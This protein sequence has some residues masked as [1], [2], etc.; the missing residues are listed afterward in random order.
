MKREN[1]CICIRCK[2]QSWTQL[3][4]FCTPRI[5]FWFVLLS[6]FERSGKIPFHLAGRRNTIQ[7]PVKSANRTRKIN[8]QNAERKIYCRIN[9]VF[10][11]DRFALKIYHI[12]ISVQLFHSWIEK[13]AEQSKNN[14][15]SRWSPFYATFEIYAI[16]S[17]SVS[18]TTRW[19]RFEVFFSSPFHGLKP[20]KK[21]FKGRLLL[22]YNYKLGHLDLPLF[23]IVLLFLSLFRFD[24]QNENCGATM[25][26]TASV[27]MHRRLC[28]R[29]RSEVWSNNANATCVGASW[30]GCWF[31]HLS[32]ES[33][34]WWVRL[35]TQIWIDR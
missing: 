7:F 31:G 3:T 13:S 2:Y 12:A 35:S 15:N 25:D 20:R 27:S 9:F 30:C 33:V 14:G 10:T 17:H 22:F 24:F 16:S 21:N 4:V 19:D 11:C 6:S 1:F 34:W 18:R 23:I 5:C 8:K 28:I 29:I 32:P 26:R